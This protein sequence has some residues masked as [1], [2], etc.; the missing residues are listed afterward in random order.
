MNTYFEYKENDI[1]YHCR[2]DGTA[3][4][5]RCH[6]WRSEIKIPETV[7]G[8]RVTSIGENAFPKGN[9]S[10]LS[11]PAS[12]T[13]IKSLPE[14]FS[15]Q[16]WERPRFGLRENAM[17]IDEEVLVTCYYSVKIIVKAGSFAEQYCKDNNIRCIV[18]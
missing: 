8:Y 1:T 11:I 14:D 2:P 13:E 9:C 17:D 7:N 6:G 5:T 16:T 12:V 18:K 10:S 3:E 15:E 4:F